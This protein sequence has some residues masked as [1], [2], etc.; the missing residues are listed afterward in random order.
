MSL[1]VVDCS[2]KS[3]NLILCK[4]PASFLFQLGPNYLPMNFLRPPVSVQVSLCDRFPAGSFEKLYK[5]CQR[6][7]A[8]RSQ[9][10]W[11]IVCIKVNLNWLD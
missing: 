2:L 7:T 9:K 11:G 8:P 10:P 4:F 6:A 1:I 5:V 3:K